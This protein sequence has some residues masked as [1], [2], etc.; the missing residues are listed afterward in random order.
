MRFIKAFKYCTNELLRKKTLKYSYIVIA[1]NQGEVG[2]QI[3]IKDK[4]SMHIAR[5]LQAMIPK[6]F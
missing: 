1:A 2:R 5:L 4:S 6:P 3:E